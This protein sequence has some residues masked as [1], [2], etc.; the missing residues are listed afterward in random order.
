MLSWAL[1]QAGHKAQSIHFEISAEKLAFS[2]EHILIKDEIKSFEVKN[3]SVIVLLEQLK[4][5]KTIQSIQIDEISFRD[6][7]RPNESLQKVLSMIK[8]RSANTSRDCI[9]I[10]QINSLSFAVSAS[11]EPI[12]IKNLRG[13]HVCLDENLTFDDLQFQSEDLQFQEGEI[14]F[15]ARPDQFWDV[16]EPR[17]IRFLLKPFLKTNEVL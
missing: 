17:K 3:L 2:A 16:K 1:S 6:L 7:T 13:R 10:L 4:R 9:E 5:E 14:I 15:T 8:P 12:Q 11:A